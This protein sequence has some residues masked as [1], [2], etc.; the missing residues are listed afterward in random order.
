MAKKD[1]KTLRTT[2]AEI[3]R[4]LE[5]LRPLWEGRPEAWEG[6]EA[7]YTVRNVRRLLRR[8]SG[9][10]EKALGSGHGKRQ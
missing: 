3:D 10:L 2:K 8:A 5:H 9:R 7:T 1:D 4:A 6:V